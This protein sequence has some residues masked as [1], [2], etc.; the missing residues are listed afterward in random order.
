MNNDMKKEIVVNAI[1]GMN[2]NDIECMVC[3]YIKY[4]PSSNDE[5]LHTQAIEIYDAMFA[6]LYEVVTGIKGECAPHIGEDACNAEERICDILDGSVLVRGIYRDVDDNGMKTTY[7]IDNLTYRKSRVFCP[8]GASI[9]S[10]DINRFAHGV[11]VFLI[12]D[13]IKKELGM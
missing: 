6:D 7:L 8:E 13:D 3:K 1:N 12:G 11:N 4:V 2:R 10:D 5:E 9:M